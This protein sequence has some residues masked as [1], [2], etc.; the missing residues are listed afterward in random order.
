MAVLRWFL[1]VP[2]SLAC[3][4]VLTMLARILSRRIVILKI[5]TGFTAGFLCIA[6][7]GWIAP[8]RQTIVMAVLAVLY[9]FYWMSEARKVAVISSIVS[10][11]RVDWLF[12][13]CILGGIVAAFS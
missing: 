2:L 11:Q 8:S 13:S 5:I 1:V 9:G 3:G 4:I 12:V 7:A 6:V 10:G